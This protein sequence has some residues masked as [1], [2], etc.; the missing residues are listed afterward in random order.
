MN[1]L[2]QNGA[3][4]NDKNNVGMTPLMF[5]SMKG[6]EDIVKKLIEHKAETNVKNVHGKTALNFADEGGHKNIHEIL[7]DDLA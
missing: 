1:L 5:A 3:S 6:S 2:I 7:L 4:I